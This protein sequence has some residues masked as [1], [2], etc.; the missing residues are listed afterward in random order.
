MIISLFGPDGVGKSS[1]AKLFADNGFQIFSGTGV[2]SWPDRSWINELNAEGLDETRINEESHFLEKIKRAHELARS[3]EIELD[4]VI[5]S[6]PLHKTLMH[7]LL[8]QVSKNDYD[9]IESRYKQLAKLANID[10]HYV[11]VHMRISENLSDDEQAK[12]LYDRIR[13]RG[14]LAPFDPETLEESVEMVRA[15]KIISDRLAA[16]GHSVVTVNTADQID[17]EMIRSLIKF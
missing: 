13:T 5:D 9:K 2:A 7:D 17:F 8:K 11:H 6:D 12:I 4:V 1:L 16:D 3:L 15:C 14:V 10:N